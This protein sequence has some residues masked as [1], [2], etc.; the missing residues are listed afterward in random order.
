MAQ[1]A[2]GKAFRK[3]ISVAKL[4]ETFSTGEVAEEWFVEQRWPQGVCCPECGSFN[5]QT[6]KTRKP[7]PY[8]CR[9]C[10]KDFSVKTGTL[11]QGAKLGFKV[12]TIAI[13]QLSTNLKS[14]SSMKLGRDLE[15]TQKTAWYLAQRIHE[16]WADNKDAL[17]ISPDPSESMRTTWAGGG[18]T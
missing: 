8:R 14:V 5:V 17:A 13:Y 15:V 7:Q 10:R 3:G 12:W 11:M 4:F 16:T 9:N 6:P 2:L 18:A 1:K